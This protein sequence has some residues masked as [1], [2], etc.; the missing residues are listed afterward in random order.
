MNALFEMRVLRMAAMAFVACGQI[1]AG[2]NVWSSIGPFG[3]F[4]HAIAIDPQD[5]DTVF[6]GTTGGIFK[7]TNGGTSW[8]L[9]NSGLPAG[10]IARSLAID[11][12]RSNIVYAAGACGTYGSCG[13]FK[14]LDGGA[15]WKAINSGLESVI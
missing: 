4:A 2:I 15:G 13:I 14:S 10:Y 11:P 1:E 12:Q 8:K 7:T 9:A 5:P 6:A 3:G